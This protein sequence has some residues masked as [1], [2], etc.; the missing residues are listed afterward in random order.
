MH[1][2][3]VYPNGRKAD[4]LILS[5]SRNT[6]RIVIKRRGDTA[7]FRRVRGVWTSED[8]SRIEFASLVMGSHT[9]LER[10]GH[11]GAARGA[12]AAA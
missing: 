4:G 1:T 2:I 9:A 8:G 5:A 12:F 10:Y 7:E 3:L 6:M 11:F